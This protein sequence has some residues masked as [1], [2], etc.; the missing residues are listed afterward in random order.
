MSVKGT[1]SGRQIV[2]DKKGITLTFKDWGENEET[3]RQRERCE[4][5]VPFFNQ[6]TK[7]EQ[8]ECLRIFGEV[9]EDLVKYVNTTVEYRDH[10]NGFPYVIDNLRIILQ[11][12]DDNDKRLSD[13]VKFLMIASLRTM[14]ILNKQN[15]EL[16]FSLREYFDNTSTFLN[17]AAR[18]IIKQD[19]ARSELN[20]ILYDNFNVA[21]LRIELHQDNAALAWYLNFVFF[22]W[23]VEPEKT[24]RILLQEHSVYCH[25][26]LVPVVA[27]SV[28]KTPRNRAT[29]TMIKR[30]ATEI[31]YQYTTGLVS[32]SGAIALL[33]GHKK[34]DILLLR[35]IRGMFDVSLLDFDNYAFFNYKP[36]KESLLHMV[37][38]TMVAEKD[39]NHFTLTVEEFFEK[40]PYRVNTADMECVNK[41]AKKLFKTMPDLSAYIGISPN[42]YCFV[43]QLLNKNEERFLEW[44]SNTKHLKPQTQW[45]VVD[46]CYLEFA[47]DFAEEGNTPFSLLLPLY[48]DEDAFHTIAEDQWEHE[49]RMVQVSSNVMLKF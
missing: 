28:R 2:I 17:P 40:Y 35:S 26:L 49:Q 6:L 10:T 37:R 31:L 5:A 18:R 12:P 45:L 36:D 42:L 46:S 9:D 3:P 11:L 24:L 22:H 38:Q 44:V 20:A 48:E 14:K 1:V 19:G 8:E 43:F 41:F 21:D 23:K 27:N 4:V 13:F 47:A 16:I 33:N 39:T 29:T 7:T 30:I 15:I 34:T 25:E 32:Y